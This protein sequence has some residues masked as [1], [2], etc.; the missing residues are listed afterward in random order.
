MKYNPYAAIA[1]L[2]MLSACA[3]Q[4]ERIE[5]ERQSS[6]FLEQG[7]AIFNKDAKNRK[8]W[9]APTISDLDQDGYLDILINDHGYGLR[10]MWNNEGKLAFPYDILMGDLHGVSVGDL[11]FDGQLELIISRGGGSGSN[12]RNAKIYSVNKQRQLVEWKELKEPLASMRGRTVKLVDLDNDGDLDLLNFAFPDRKMREQNL[13]ENYIYENIGKG[14]MVIRSTLPS[15]HGDGQKTL[16]TDINQDHIPDI[17]LYGHGAVKVYQGREHFDYEDVTKQVLPNALHNVTAIA[18]IDY[19]NDGDFDL[20]FT[21]GLP[22]EKGDVFFDKKTKRLGFY[23]KRGPFQ[24]DD[25]NIGDTLLIENYQS[26]WPEKLP[27][28]AEPGYKYPYKGETHSG[29]TIEL[30]SS[31]A[32]GFPDDISDSSGVYIGYVGNNKWR[33]AG[34][35]FAP[36]SGVVHGVED[37]KTSAKPEG[38]SDLLLENQNGKFIDVSAKVGLIDTEH[39]TGVTIGDF[40]N[41]GFSDVLVFRRGNLIS[42]NNALMYMNHSANGQSRVFEKLENSGV[43]STELGATGMSGEV[44]DYDNDGQ[45]DVVTGHERGMWHLYRN[46]GTLPANNGHVQVNV[47]LSPNQKAS[48][49][50][51]LV[52][53]SACNVSQVRRIGS[54]GANYSM[55][56]NHQLLFGIGS[57]SDDYQVSVKWTNG[58]TK[59]SKVKA[60]E[61]AISM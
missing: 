53:V 52:T 18:E 31:D 25:F 30:V 35:V 5:L 20:L 39:S 2:M 47:G 45:L 29:R 55:S 4:T 42:A 11:N 8:G 40:D 49:L 27:Y 13:S 17:L 26:P 37:Y 58:E 12:A 7:E 19:D 33:L 46:Q 6:A 44:L 50:G 14:E 56:F 28:I 38:L 43:F 32:L 57:C 41:N 22:F 61:R 23:T 21:R 54:N 59:A 15:V 51:A 1:S 60:N 3:S 36:F 24:F 34:N 48:A 9:D 10:V 16:V